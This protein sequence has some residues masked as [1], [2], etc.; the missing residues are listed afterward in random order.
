MYDNYAVLIEFFDN[1]SKEKNENGAKASGYSKQ[2]L[3]FYFLFYTEI[4][5]IIFERV[6]ILNS[7]FQ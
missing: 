4:M 7:E 3:I 6:E 5:I 2:F 1:I